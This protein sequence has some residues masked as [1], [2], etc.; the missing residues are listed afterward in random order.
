[1]PDNAEKQEAPPPK[2]AAGQSEI[3]RVERLATALG[4]AEA[5]RREEA[6][7]ADRLQRTVDEQAQIIHGLEQ[8]VNRLRRELQRAQDLHSPPQWSQR[9]AMF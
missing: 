9:R 6:D 8:E 3:A 5:L 7:R 4:K 2:Q 1:M